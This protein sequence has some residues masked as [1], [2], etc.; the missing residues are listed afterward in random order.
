MECEKFDKEKR[1]CILCKQAHDLWEIM[2]GLKR[3]LGPS[4][5]WALL[6]AYIDIL[7]KNYTEEEMMAIT[8]KID[9]LQLLE[10]FSLN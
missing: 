7:A 6:N 10:S 8:K 5:A 3:K 9:T 1:N 4:L 2:N